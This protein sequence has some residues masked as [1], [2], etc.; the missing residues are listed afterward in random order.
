MRHHLPRPESTRLSTLTALILLTYGLIRMMVLPSVTTDLSLLGLLIRFEFKTQTLMLAIA[1]GLAAAG[2][3]WLIEGHP[4]TRPRQNRSEHWVI[5]A[6]AALAI[7]TIVLRVQPG[8]AQWLGFVLGALFLVSILWAEFIAHD[9]SDPRYDLI[10][11]G[12]KGLALLLLSGTFFIVEAI[13]LRA[14]FTLPTVL[15]LGS[16]VSWRLMRLSHPK[17]RVWSWAVLTGVLTAQVA[18]GLHYW[19]ISPLKSALIL[20]LCAYLSHQIMEAQLRNG[21]DQRITIEYFM[22]GAIALIAIL[23]LA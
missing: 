5:P 4:K 8:V 17:K 16:I 14:I 15:L 21:I 12:L 11:V 3:D 1:A 20:S 23:S 6:L 19:P 2:S 9:P 10:S 7:G 13:P 18:I 22:V